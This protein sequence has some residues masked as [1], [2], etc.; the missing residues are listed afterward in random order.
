MQVELWLVSSI[1]CEE[2]EEG[3]LCVLYTN[4]V[5]LLLLL[6]LLVFALVVLS[7]VLTF[8]PDFVICVIF[9]EELLVLIVIIVPDVGDITAAGFVDSGVVNV[10]SRY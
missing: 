5:L 1:I 2:D 8:E 9:G 3:D 10:A 7:M 6:L 4:T